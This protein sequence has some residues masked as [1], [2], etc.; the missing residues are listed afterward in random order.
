MKWEKSIPLYNSFPDTASLLFTSWEIF[1]AHNPIYILFHVI[2]LYTWFH[3][4]LRNIY[5]SVCIDPFHSLNILISILLY[6]CDTL[7]VSPLPIDTEVILFS[8]EQGF[9]I[10]GQISLYTWTSGSLRYKFLEFLCQRLCVH[11]KNLVV[12]PNCLPNNL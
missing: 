4:Y 6:D 5:I 1:V 10:I 11:W 7:L 9:S 2:L 12:L 3:S 8:S